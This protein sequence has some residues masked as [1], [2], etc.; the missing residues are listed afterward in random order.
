M[1]QFIGAG[2]DLIHLDEAIGLAGR[3]DDRPLMAI[4]HLYRSTTRYNEG[5]VPGAIAEM[6]AAI[7]ALAALSAAERA[8]LHER[9]QLIGRTLDEA[10]AKGTLAWQL[11]IAGFYAEA[12][13]LTEGVTS[14]ERATNGDMLLARTLVSAGLGMPDAAREA[15]ASARR[16]YA[17]VGHSTKW[18]SCCGSSSRG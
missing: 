9:R 4:A 12:R 16:A 2:R 14:G 6:R 7:A 10:Q 15:A 18:R 13:A 8:L 1:R 11:A 5:D 3:A 17:A